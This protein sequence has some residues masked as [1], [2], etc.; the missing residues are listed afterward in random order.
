MKISTPSILIISASLIIQTGCVTTPTAIQM[1]EANSMLKQ[2]AKKANQGDFPGANDAAAAIGNAVR[3]GVELAPVVPSKTGQ[4]VDLK[5]L[6][7]AWESGP[8]KDLRKALGNG[9]KEASTAAF[10]NLKGQCTNCHAAIGRPE[11][12]IYGMR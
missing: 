2:S 1:K 12:R 7:A 10:D 11:I 4:D 5:P 6:L 9:Q 8:Y 3:V